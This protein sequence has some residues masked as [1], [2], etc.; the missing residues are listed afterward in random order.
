[1]TTTTCTFDGCELDHD[2]DLPHAAC[3]AW[4]KGWDVAITRH[5]GDADEGWL[6]AAET[7]DHLAPAEAEAFAEAV[8]RASRGLAAIP[9]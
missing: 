5:E 7:T 8:T 4:G 3:V 2:H 6:L 9:A 1:M